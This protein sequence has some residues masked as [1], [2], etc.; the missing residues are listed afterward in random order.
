MSVQANCPSPKKLKE[1]T[2]ASEDDKAG[3][4]QQ[5]RDVTSDDL[6]ENQ[7]AQSEPKDGKGSDIFTAGT[8]KLVKEQ[9]VGAD[10]PTPATKLAKEQQVGAEQHTPATKL[11]KERQVGPKC[12]SGSEQPTPATKLVKE[13]QVG[14][15]SD[16]DGPPDEVAVS[17]KAAD[18]PA[19]MMGQQGPPPPKAAS[20]AGRRTERAA[21]EVERRLLKRSKVP[22]TLL[23]RL[24]KSEISRE[25]DELLQCLR[26]VCSKDFFGAAAAGKK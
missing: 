25:R 17:K 2:T 10:Q 8:T 22:P 1:C 23:E 9:Q 3:A 7:S 11:V 6:K 13:Q 15:G 16:S 4:G 21:R 24:L 5:E 18:Q 14:C 19:L 26:F 12:E 20:A